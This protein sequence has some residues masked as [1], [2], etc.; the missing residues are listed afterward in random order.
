MKRRR[1]IP[2]LVVALAGIA[3][4]G[5]IAIYNRRA[6]SDIVADVRAEEL[7]GHSGDRALQQYV[8]ID[9]SNPPGREL[10]GA[11][12]LADLLRKHGLKPEIIESAPGRA[13]VYARLEGKRRGEGLP[14][15]NHIDVVPADPKMRIGAV[16]GGHL[17]QSVVGA[18]RST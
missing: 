16:R 14:L 18:D 12:F 1:F 9:T 17:R 3:V 8:R 10:A 11:Q 2:I 4:V 7:A 15:L 13:N 5:G 6:D